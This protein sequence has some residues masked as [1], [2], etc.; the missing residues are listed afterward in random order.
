M[1]THF[2]RRLPRIYGNSARAWD[3]VCR[4]RSRAVRMGSRAQLRQFFSPIGSQSRFSPV[5]SLDR[6]VHRK[7]K[8]AV[9]ALALLLK[10]EIKLKPEG[11]QYGL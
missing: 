4:T 7:P 1:V 5:H 11:K 10:G 9:P 8:P 3:P 6:L 2:G